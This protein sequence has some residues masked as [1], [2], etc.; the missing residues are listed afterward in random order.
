MVE[1]NL[2]LSVKIEEVEDTLSQE[3]ITVLSSDMLDYIALDPKAKE[4]AEAL[5]SRVDELCTKFHEDDRIQLLATMLDDMDDDFEELISEG[6]T[7]LAENGIELSNLDNSDIIKL[8]C[9]Y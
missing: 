2:K 6:V 8:C 7:D 3:Q 1:Q 4:L 5:K 9:L